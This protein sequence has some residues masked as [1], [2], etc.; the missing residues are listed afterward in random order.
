MR[1]GLG[2]GRGFPAGGKTGQQFLSSGRRGG[3]PRGLRSGG[4]IGEAQG[5]RSG[6]K[7][8]EG[9]PESARGSQV[10]AR[11]RNP[12]SGQVSLG[13]ETPGL[14]TKGEEVLGED[15]WVQ[16]GDRKPPTTRATKESGAR[17]RDKKITHGPGTTASTSPQRGTAADDDSAEPQQRH[18][19]SADRAGHE[20]GIQ[21][22]RK[23]GIL[24]LEETAG[25]PA[26]TGTQ[27]RGAGNGG[28]RET[29]YLGGT[30][31]DT[32]DETGQ[33]VI[34]AHGRPAVN[35]KERSPPQ[36]LRALN[37]CGHQEW[38]ESG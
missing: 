32:G 12:W 30:E 14:S 13:E 5:L 7:I 17:G 24:K 15:R 10:A 21:S 23:Y 6:L 36:W 33:S 25:D 19:D 26:A 34:V 8:R 31:T 2:Q 18:S 35:N 11:H 28:T 37:A 29:A 1:Q 16:G 22:R 27:V 4:Q 3:G 38:K 9:L 20:N